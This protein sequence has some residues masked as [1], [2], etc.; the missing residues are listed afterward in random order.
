MAFT[1]KELDR[2]ERIYGDSELEPTDPQE[3]RDFLL[4][5]KHGSKGKMPEVRPKALDHF[6]LDIIENRT[7]VPEPPKLPSLAEATIQMMKK[8]DGWDKAMDIIYGKEDKS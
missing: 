8:D 1:Q 2:M 5:K 3:L 4:W 6:Y 7:G